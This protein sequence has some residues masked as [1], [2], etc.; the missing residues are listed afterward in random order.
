MGFASV[1]YVHVF[2]CLTCMNV[3]VH[4]YI[5]VHF[6]HACIDLHACLLE[7]VHLGGLSECV[8]LWSVPVCLSSVCVCLSGGVLMQ[9]AGICVH[10]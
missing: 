10:V 5:C 6:V 4:V 8:Y 3:C 1:L 9:C 2:D 7:C